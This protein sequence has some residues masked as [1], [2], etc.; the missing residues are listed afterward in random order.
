MVTGVC[1][2][3]PWI[4]YNHW[5]ASQDSDDTHNDFM[6]NGPNDDVVFDFK[7]WTDTDAD[8]DTT[9]FVA[10]AFNAEMPEKGFQRILR[11]EQ[12]KRLHDTVSVGS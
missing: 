9:Y 3:A 8:G 5:G 10:Y 6:C 4:W 12:N 2:T 7:K 11:A 1:S